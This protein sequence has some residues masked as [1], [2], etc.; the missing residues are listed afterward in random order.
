MNFVLIKKSLYGN[1]IPSFDTRLTSII[2]LKQARSSFSDNKCEEKNL[3]Q[4]EVIHW[5]AKREGPGREDRVRPG[6]VL[7]LC[8]LLV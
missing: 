1:F 6:V 8:R 2:F 4:V 3:F 7:N 5:V